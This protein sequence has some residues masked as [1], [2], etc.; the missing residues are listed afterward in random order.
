MATRFSRQDMLGGI[1]TIFF[2]QIKMNVKVK[3]QL[4]DGITWYNTIKYEK[5]IEDE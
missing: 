2:E 1:C 3:K 4:V 5:V